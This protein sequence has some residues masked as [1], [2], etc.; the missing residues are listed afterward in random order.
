[1]RAA[2]ASRCRSFYSTY[3][4]PV[5]QFG[6]ERFFEIVTEQ[7]H[8]RAHHSRP[9][10]RRGCRG[11]RDGGRG[12]YS[13]DSASRADVERSGRANRRKARGF[14]YCVSSLGVT[15]VRADFQ[16]GIDEFLATV[17]GATDMPIAVGF[18]ISSR[19]QVERFAKQADGVIVGSAIVRKIEEVVPLL[20]SAGYE[21]GR[22]CAD[23]RVRKR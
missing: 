4:N 13:S 18:G 22:T 15:G 12:Q 16:Q 14:V 20:Q 23:P 3:Y 10:D 19:E 6:L 1:M 7:R 17:R 11:S 9:A 5:L 8:Q 21:A 2:Q